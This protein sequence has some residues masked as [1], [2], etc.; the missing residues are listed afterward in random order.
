MAAAR[1]TGDGLREDS[2]KG[3]VKLVM[4]AHGDSSGLDR[5]ESGH[6]QADKGCHVGFGDLGPAL[7]LGGLVNGQDAR[8]GALGR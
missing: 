1:G 5:Q 6:E 2:L 4:C 7:G 3:L 8:D